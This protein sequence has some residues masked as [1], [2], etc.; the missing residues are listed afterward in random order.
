[1]I[2]MTKELLLVKIKRNFKNSKITQIYETIQSQL[3]NYLNGLRPRNIVYIYVKDEMAFV[4]RFH[5]I[6]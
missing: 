5:F 1:M 2:W 4:V 3:T 6:I